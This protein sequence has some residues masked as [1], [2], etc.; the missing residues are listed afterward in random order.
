MN[1]LLIKPDLC[2]LQLK[3]KARESGEAETGVTLADSEAVSDQEEEEEH[4]FAGRQ[5]SDANDMA[6]EGGLTSSD[7]EENQNEAAQPKPGKAAYFGMQK[8]SNIAPAKEY[9]GLSLAEQEAL[10]LRMIKRG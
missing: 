4:E 3:R 2:E 8:K 6:Y 9:E 10:A 7:D 1:Y 5:E